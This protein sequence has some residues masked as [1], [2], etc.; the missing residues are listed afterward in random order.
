[1]QKVK[2]ELVYAACLARRP[3]PPSVFIKYKANHR[4]K[5]EKVSVIVSCF[6]WPFG[7]SNTSTHGQ[8]V[9]FC[10]CCSFSNLNISCRRI[11][12]CHWCQN[13]FQHSQALL[14]LIRKTFGH[15][16]SSCESLTYLKT[17]SSD[18][19]RTKKLF[20]KLTCIKYL[21]LFK[22]RTQLESYLMYFLSLDN[23]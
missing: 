22:I 1:M 9:L 8:L 23:L 7:I 12:Y 18:S 13:H 5:I 19:S 11:V 17:V 15:L 20:L 6:S 4:K 10:H 16:K 3:S 21:F 14:F 2:K